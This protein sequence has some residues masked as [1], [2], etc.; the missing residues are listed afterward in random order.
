MLA[1]LLLVDRMHYFSYSSFLGIVCLLFNL[2]VI[3]YFAIG[4][5]NA[6][7]SHKWTDFVPTEIRFNKLFSV[8]GGIV[9]AFESVTSIFHIRAD[10]KKP[11][12]FRKILKI[13][14]IMTIIIYAIFA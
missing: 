11:K 5:I 14:F 9:W 12:D 6:D 10:M 1:P 4:Q 3:T 2:I 7:N 8:F 13:I